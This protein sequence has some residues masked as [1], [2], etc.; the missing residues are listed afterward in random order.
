M[1][2]PA[3]WEEVSRGAEGRQP[4]MKY[5]L[6]HFEQDSLGE[7]RAVWMLGKE[8]KRRREFTFIDSLSAVCQAQW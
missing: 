5:L 1:R 7:G 4:E 2:T 6:Q 8:Q 3:V